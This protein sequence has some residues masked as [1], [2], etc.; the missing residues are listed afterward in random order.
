MKVHPKFHELLKVLAS[1]PEE[2]DSKSLET[3]ISQV[4]H[5][6]FFDAH[7]IYALTTNNSWSF[8]LTMPAPRISIPF[9]IQLL[10]VFQLI[11]KPMSSPLQSLALER[12][13]VVGTTMRQP[14]PCAHSSTR[15]NLLQTHC[16][17]YAL[18]LYIC[19]YLITVH[20]SQCISTES[21]VWANCYSGEGF[22]LVPLSLWYCVQS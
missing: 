20:E 6:C 8:T 14:L 15:Q 22:A 3:F 9:A 13:I 19:A 5:F 11:H 17:Y 2:E 7:R 16:M 4:C 12:I 21:R 10:D 1:E 18:I